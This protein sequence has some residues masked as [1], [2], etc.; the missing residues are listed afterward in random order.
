MRLILT[1][2]THKNPAAVNN[3]QMSLRAITLFQ[4]VKRRR[5]NPPH[6]LGEQTVSQA[7]FAPQTEFG[8]AFHKKSIT[9]LV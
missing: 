6:S 9:H 5:P 8:A 3:N 1:H 2:E 7:I 4:S